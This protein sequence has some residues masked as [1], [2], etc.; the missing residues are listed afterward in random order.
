MSRRRPIK[1]A[2]GSGYSTA[3]THPDPLDPN[4]V[5]RQRTQSRAGNFPYDSPTSYGGPIGTDLGGAAYQRAP[6]GTPPKPRSKKASD[7]I[8]YGEYGVAWEQLESMLDPYSP[9]EQ[10]DDALLLGYGSHGRLGEDD[11]DDVNSLQK[12]FQLSV[13]TDAD[14]MRGLNPGL[15]SLL[16]IDSDCECHADDSYDGDWGEHIYAPGAED[17]PI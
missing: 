15:L 14:D 17:D 4:D 13:P 10:A 9:G 8:P 12:M 16:S 7:A 11:D 2:G 1:E 5:Q 3:F 6:D